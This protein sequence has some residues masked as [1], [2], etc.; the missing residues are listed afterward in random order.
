MSRVGTEENEALSWWRASW[1]TVECEKDSY[2][3]RC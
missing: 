1:I 3:A 2:R